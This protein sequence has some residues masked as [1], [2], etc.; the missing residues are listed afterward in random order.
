[1]PNSATG[2][3]ICPARPASRA[4][5]HCSGASRPS[6]PPST[7]DRTDLMQEIDSPTRSIIDYV[8]SV[9]Y[10]A[11]PPRAVHAVTRNFVDTVACMA[12]GCEGLAARATRAYARTGTGTPA[13]SAAGVDAPVLLDGAVLAN[14]AAVA[15]GEFYDDEQVRVPPS[16]IGPAPVAL[17]ES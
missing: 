4:S 1:M 7:T 13:A 2:S 14:C 11:L 6:R 5:R 12:G 3:G 10:A 8:A 16:P 15:Q 17:A 9:T